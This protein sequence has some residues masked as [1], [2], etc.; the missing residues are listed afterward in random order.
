MG[1]GILAYGAY[2]S[3]RRLARQSI[4]DASAWFNPALDH[5]DGGVLFCH[6]TA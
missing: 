3:R 1:I 4:A 5:G 2:I 6:V